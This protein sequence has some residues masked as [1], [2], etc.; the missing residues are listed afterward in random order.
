V[1]II[2]EYLRKTTDGFCDKD[3]VLS[4]FSKASK[5]KNFVLDRAIYQRDLKRIEN[6]IIE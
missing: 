1:V 6:L 2:P 5:Y 4:H 3:I